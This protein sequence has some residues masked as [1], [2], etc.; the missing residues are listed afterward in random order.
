[1]NVVLWI[2]QAVLA[3][4]F[5]MAGAMKI[6]KTKEQLAEQMGWVEEFDASRILSIGVL[7]VLGAIGLILPGATGIGPQLVPLAAIGLGV[8]MVLAAQVHLRRSEMPNV[9]VNGILLLGLL[10]VAVG[11][12]FDY[13]V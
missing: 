10:V 2:V 3:F 1:M 12:F 6:A 11:R 4:V 5:L 9:A 13:V 8:M 7:E